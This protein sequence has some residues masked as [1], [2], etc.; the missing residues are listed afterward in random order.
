MNTVAEEFDYPIADMGVYIQPIVQGVN[1]HCEFNLFFDP[2]NIREVDKIKR[3]PE[4]AFSALTARGAFFSRPYGSIADMAY[5]KDAATTMAL[6]KIK[7]IYDP[8]NIMNPG[9]LCF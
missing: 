4:A 5:R 6:R 1:Y 7:G 3:M 9:K 2:D 8:N